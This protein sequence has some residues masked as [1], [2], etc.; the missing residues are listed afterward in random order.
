[1]AEGKPKPP[2]PAP[3]STTRMSQEDEPVRV[4]EYPNFLT[5][6]EIE[7]FVEQGMAA[8]MK[9]ALLVGKMNGVDIQDEARTNSSAWLSHSHT[10]VTESVV[11]RIA[12]VVK[13]PLINAEQIQMIYYKPNEQYRAHFDGWKMPDD[14][15]ERS[16]EDRIIKERYMNGQGGQRLCTCLVYL[17]SVDKGGGTQ[18]VN[19]D[20]V[21]QPE[22]G[23]LLCFWNVYEGTNKLHPDSLHAGLPVEAGEK[24]AFNLWF[25]EK[26]ARR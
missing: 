25:R 12:N 2:P 17:N 1:M 7:H 13:L 10:D 20:R 11:K 15:N 24:W 21:I 6:S 9:P 19:L 22:A 8:G 18:F 14:P 3:R 5:Q 23:K 16:E 4:R 26:D